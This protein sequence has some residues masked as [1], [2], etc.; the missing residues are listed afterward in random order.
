MTYSQLKDSAAHIDED[1]L[2]AFICLNDD[3]KELIFTSNI[4]THFYFLECGYVVGLRD[5]YYLTFI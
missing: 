2:S 1:F 3:E 5:E 4:V